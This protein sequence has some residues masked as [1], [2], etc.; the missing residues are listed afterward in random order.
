MQDIDKIDWSKVLLSQS[1]LPKQ[2]LWGRLIGTLR[3]V[4]SAFYRRSIPRVEVDSGAI[5][6]LK[7]MERSDYDELWAKVLES[8]PCKTQEVEIAWPRGFSL[9]PIRR[10]RHLGC[11][12]SAAK[13]QLGVL[14]RIKG[15]VLCLYYLNAIAAF[16]GNLP[17][18]VLVLAEMQ[19]GENV[20]VQYFNARGVPTVTLQ[21][22]LYIDYGDQHTVNRLN[23]EA[24]CA[25]VFLAW[26]EET[27]ELIQKYNPDAKIVVCGAPQ[28][29]GL[30]DEQ[31]PDCIYVVF[32]ADINLDENRI[33]LEIG[34]RV[35]KEAG[36]EVVVC[37]HPRNRHAYYDFSGCT[38]RPPE[39]NY[40]RKGLVIGHTTTQ[41]IKLARYGK[42]VY[43]LR[44]AEP[45]NQMIP[46]AV[47]FSA[48]EELVDKMEQ[49]KY[50]TEW[51]KVHIAYMGE[52]SLRH[53]T[54]FFDK[55]Y[56]SHD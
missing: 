3:S 16:R 38:F 31:E 9:D 28:I 46:E 47:Q 6:C 40:S 53:Y 44:S 8:I 55:W 25:R 24:S 22:G 39:D 51:A 45:C 29:D 7:S 36:Y 19:P 10:L 17:K 37:L 30:I 14:E 5:L 48:Y 56:Q 27:G 26:G 23:Y 54:A 1:L 13:C 12:W 11:A 42:R 43:K 32:D 21:H 33:L 4:A 50:P 49:L 2:S 15:T 35:G 41:L 52:E 20:L 18:R 34:K